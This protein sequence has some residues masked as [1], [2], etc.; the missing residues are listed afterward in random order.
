MQT[1]QLGLAHR[2]DAAAWPGEAR[3]AC[4]SLSHSL[5]AHTGRTDRQPS[6]CPPNHHRLGFVLFF[7]LRKKFSRVSFALKTVPPSHKTL[8]IS[9]KKGGT[10]NYTQYNS[11][12]MNI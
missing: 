10:W 8:T 7:F 2:Q 6:G 11:N 9:H 4:L 12:L 3:K 1:Q 5:G